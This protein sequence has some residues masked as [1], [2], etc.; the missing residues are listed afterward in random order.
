MCKKSAKFATDHMYKFFQSRKILT[1]PCYEDARRLASLLG[2]ALSFDRVDLV[3]CMWAERVCRRLYGVEMALKDTT[4]ESEVTKKVK[5]HLGERYDLNA[6][7]GDGHRIS[8]ADSEVTKHLEKEA[9][10]NKWAA[11]AKFG[12]KQ[13]QFSQLL[14]F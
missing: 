4:S 3:N 13:E 5:W 14:R 10:Q 1:I 7:A 11:K 9:L 12:E 2:D 8:G 6:I